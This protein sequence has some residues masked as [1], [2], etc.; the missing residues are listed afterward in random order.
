M[1]SSST[2]SLINHPQVEKHKRMQGSLVKKKWK[3]QE[4]NTQIP[5]KQKSDTSNFTNEESKSSWKFRQH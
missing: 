2:L 5:R 4:R 1:G 3:P